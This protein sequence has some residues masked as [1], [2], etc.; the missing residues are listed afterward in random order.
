MSNKILIDKFSTS[1]NLYKI[2]FTEFS[3]SY[4]SNLYFNRSI[5][6]IKVKELYEILLYDNYENSAWICHSIYDIKSNK[7]QIIDGQ[8]RHEAVIKYID[9]NEINGEK[10]LYMIEYDIDDIN[11]KNSNIKALD[12]FKKL[13]NNSPLNP[14]D[15][16]KNKIVELMI[17]LK[18]RFEIRNG[19]GTD[20]KTKSCYSPKIHEKELFELLNKH[21]YLFKSLDINQILNNICEI[22]R[23]ISIKTLEEIF[24]NK[25]ITEKE[26]KIIEKAKLLNFYLGIKDSFY[27]P[28]YWIKY[29]NNPQNL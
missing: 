28:N 12:L 9:N 13:N 19:I 2:S 15:M 18:K 21:E 26:I 8:H 29:I 25:K 14:E 22:N 17:L 27:S 3:K 16:P 6:P 24:E 7:R 5:N 4:F 11:N 1:I 10:Y 20:N 23:L